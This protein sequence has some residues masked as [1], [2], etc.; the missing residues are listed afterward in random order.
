MARERDA[1]KFRTSPSRANLAQAYRRMAAAMVTNAS[2]DRLLKMA[3]SIEQELRDEA[4]EPDRQ[5]AVSNPVDTER[6]NHG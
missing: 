2:R 3:A 6:E 1:S 5:P 4:P